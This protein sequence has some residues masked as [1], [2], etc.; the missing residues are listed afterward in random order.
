MDALIA[1]ALDE[2]SIGVAPS[3]G[4]GPAAVPNTRRGRLQV[5]RYVTQASQRQPTRVVLA[6]IGDAWGP[7][8]RMLAR[9]GAAVEVI[10]PYGSP[11]PRGAS[12]DAQAR[13]LL[14]EWISGNLSPSARLADPDIRY[15]LA[16]DPPP[17][18]RRVLRPLLALAV[19]AAAGGAMVLRW[20]RGG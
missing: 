13:A 7:L 8:Y 19:G 15:L 12:V 16:D 20:M 9:G 6:A 1:I 17:R 14:A 3:E 4:A 5:L 11:L 2:H 10:N 18:R